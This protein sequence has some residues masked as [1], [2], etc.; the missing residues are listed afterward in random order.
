MDWERFES[1]AS[2]IIGKLDADGVPT[3]DVEAEFKS[4][5]GSY[6]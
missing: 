6:L 3:D 2:S 4:M 1:W 5:K